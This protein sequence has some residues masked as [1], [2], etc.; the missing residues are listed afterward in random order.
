[1]QTVTRVE[2]AGRHGARCR[3]LILALVASLL[4]AAPAGAATARFEGWFGGGFVNPD[5]DPNPLAVAR[6]GLGVRF[7]D[8]ISLGGSFQ[9]DR[10]HSFGFGYAGLTLPE[11]LLEPFA[12]FYAGRRDDVSDTAYGWSVGLQTGPGQVKLFADVHG[13]IQPGHGV[14]VCLG[15]TF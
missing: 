4:S 6:G 12:R 8:H 3:W 14:G 2:R 13:I 5:Y 15:F 7:V 9:A 10:D 11:T 1:M